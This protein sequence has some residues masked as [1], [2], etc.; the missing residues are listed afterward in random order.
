M[1]GTNLTRS[2]RTTA[3]NPRKPWTSL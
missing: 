2:L 3:W 1:I